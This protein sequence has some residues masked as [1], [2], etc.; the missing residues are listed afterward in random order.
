MLIAVMFI[1]KV[2][3]PSLEGR[4]N[5]LIVSIS[6]DKKQLAAIEQKILHDLHDSKGHLLD[7]EKLINALTGSKSM[8]KMITERL[9]ESV[10]SEVKIGEMGDKYFLR[11]GKRR[12]CRRVMYR[13]ECVV[14]YRK[15]KDPFMPVFS[16][17]CRH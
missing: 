14:F 15:V 1:I 3:N 6:N 9:A 13:P 11:G 8:S 2:E 7:N 5:S 12:R 17:T 16:Y 4:H 10:V